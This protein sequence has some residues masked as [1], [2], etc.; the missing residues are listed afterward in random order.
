M[1]NEGRL[2]MYNKIAVLFVVVP[3]CLINCAT[4]K[5]SRDIT[6]TGRVLDPNGKAVAGT[7]INVLPNLDDNS[8]RYHVAFVIEEPVRTDEKGTYEV[9]FDP[10]GFGP[11]RGEFLDL[12]VRN[13]D[14][15]LAAIKKFNKKSTMVDVAL[16]PGIILTGRVVDINDNPIPNASLS[17]AIHYKRKVCSFLFEKNCLT[18][19][20]NGRYEIR[21]LW[22]EKRYSIAA[23]AEGY[24][25]QSI[26]GYFIDDAPDHRMELEPLVL[27]KTDKSISGVVLDDDGKPVANARVSCY[28]DGQPSRSTLTDKDGKFALKN[29][30]AGT[31]NIQV[32]G[33]EVQLK[34]SMFCRT[35]AEAG[36]TDIK[37]IM[38]QGHKQPL[39]MVGK[40]LPDI[41]DIGI[42]ISTADTNDK[43]F[44]VCFF[45]MNQR[46]SRNCLLQ[47]GRKAKELTAKDI[48]VVAIQT[49]KVDDNVL[50]E[51]AENNN[52]PFPVGMIKGDE[53]KIRF[54]WGVRSLPWLIL[55]DKKHIVT[56]EGLSLAE[57]DEKL[58]GKSHK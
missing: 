55:T 44:L 19:D 4:G 21:A 42:A 23:K 54:S 45:D 41:K 46:P 49:S 27:K 47:L 26:A 30:C 25:T 3:F 37:I 34:S 1:K 10:N 6:L 14:L 52:I 58:A 51:W 16:S 32:I 22:P 9:Q 29:I 39:P 53:E 56:A 5:E 50:K 20:E 57:L 18:S 24:G 33:P 15:N 8:Q 40:P 43:A 38:S 2:T 13:L 17:F 12:Y 36:A 28:G 48:I 11:V 35:Y 7:L 31:V